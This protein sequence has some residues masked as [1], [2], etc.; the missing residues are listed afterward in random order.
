M[1]ELI[2]LSDF[3][4]FPCT[5]CFKCSNNNPCVIKD[6]C[7]G[8]YRK[9]AKSDVIVLGSPVHFGNISGMMKNFFDRHNGNAMFNPVEMGYLP[10]IPKNKRL[11]TFMKKISKHYRPLN[12][13][14]GKKIK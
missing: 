3:I 4:I 14:T 11:K 7:H 6:D 13:I 5:G 1:I 12:E 8:I 2:N 9:S 10:C